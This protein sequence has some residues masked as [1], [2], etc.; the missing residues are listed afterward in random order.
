MF[1]LESL[2]VGLSVVVVSFIDDFGELFIWF[3]L[4]SFYFEYN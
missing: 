4:G 2:I 1:I 3:D